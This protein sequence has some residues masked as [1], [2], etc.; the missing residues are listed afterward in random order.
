MYNLYTSITDS[1]VQLR[2]TRDFLRNIHD[3]LREVKHVY[4]VI[5]RRFIRKRNVIF[6]LQS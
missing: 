4:S 6:L 3:I 1:V 5:S 2:V